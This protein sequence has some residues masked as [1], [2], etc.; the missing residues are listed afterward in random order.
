MTDYRE[1]SS[2]LGSIGELVSE[3]RK[4]RGA[5]LREIERRTGITNSNILRVTRGENCTVR[6]ARALLAW[7][8][9][10]DITKEE[11]R[12]MLGDEIPQKLERTGSF[13][14][15]DSN[16]FVVPRGMDDDLSDVS[17]PSGDVSG[18]V[19]GQG[20]VLPFVRR[21]VPVVDAATGE[22]TESEAPSDQERPGGPETGGSEIHE[23][24]EGD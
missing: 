4:E 15:S 18:D 24:P 3:A 20:G 19:G 9:D 12:R 10:P 7:L 16:V 14:R 21:S 13:T 11:V 2:V 23:P 5:T 6:H 8:D 22:P 1:I 17:E